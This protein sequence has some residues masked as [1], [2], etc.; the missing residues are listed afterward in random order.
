MAKSRIGIDQLPTRL[1]AGEGGEAARPLA[2]LH[3]NKDATVHANYGVI[4]ETA[5]NFT[6]GGVIGSASFNDNTETQG[7]VNIDHHY[8]YQ[9][10]ARVNTSSGTLSSLTALNSKF[11]L[12]AGT[13]N[14]C[15]GLVYN[16]PVVTSGTTNYN[17]G[18]NIATLTQ[19]VLEN[20][21]VYIGGA[22][23]GSVKNYS[24]YCASATAPIHLG[25]KLDIA[26]GGT[27]KAD[28]GWD[29]TTGSIMLDN[30]STSAK[31]NIDTFETRFT[32]GQAFIGV[33]TPD[34]TTLDAQLHVKG[35]NDKVALFLEN[36]HPT[37]P[38]EWFI[39]TSEKTVALGGLSFYDNLAAA[40]R[41]YITTAGVVRP[42][43]DGTQDLGDATHRW[44][45]VYATTG[46]INTSD[47][48]EKD[49][50]E[51]EDAEILAAKELKTAIR[52]YRFK[53]DHKKRFGIGA[54]TVEKIMAKHGLNADDYGFFSCVDDRYGINYSELLCFLSLA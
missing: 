7:T 31:L 32:N 17:I 9:T 24:I 23:G 54:Q 48:R 35:P 30:I 46:T 29:D 13:V 3:I 53:N 44:Q 4:D 26:F 43:G 33:G 15:T 2:G 16:D 45:T 41:L 25:G 52:K 5:Y 49:F 14:V 21:G 8:S 1:V 10:N 36:N 18:V 20:I 40:V 39:S 22:S 11:Y 28:F 47:E 51:I 37:D 34:A 27:K 19:G 50:L 6:S 38:S 12:D 42:G